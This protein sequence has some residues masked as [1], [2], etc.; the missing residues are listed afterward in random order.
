[1]VRKTFYIEKSQA[2]A[3]R[4]L[5]RQTGKSKPDLLRE[6]VDLAIKKHQKTSRS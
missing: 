6:A 2:T 4:R 5:A 1:M 3:L